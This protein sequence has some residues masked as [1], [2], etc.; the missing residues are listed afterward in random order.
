MVIAFWA[1]RGAV[2]TSCNAYCMA[3]VWGKRLR[4][5]ATGAKHEASDI[6]SHH[7][8][9]KNWAHCSKQ[10]ESSF[11]VASM[12]LV[13]VLCVLGVSLWARCLSIVCV[14]PSLW[15]ASVLLPVGA[16]AG[17]GDSSNLSGATQALHC[18]L[19]IANRDPAQ[20]PPP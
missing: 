10:P 9:Q 8:H 12:L 13:F 20:P 7:R 5:C 3:C 15:H 17:S 2:I 18:Q 19:T 14:V 16:C 4:I 1:A 6:N 11:L